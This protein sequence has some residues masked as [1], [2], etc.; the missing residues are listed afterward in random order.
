MRFLRDFWAVDM[1]YVL[2]GIAQDSAAPARQLT[3]TDYYIAELVIYI[4]VK[5][6]D[7]LTLPSHILY[8]SANLPHSLPQGKH[9]HDESIEE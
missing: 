5:L 7:G 1:E 6:Q 9:D 4:Q 8:A 3:W 2:Q